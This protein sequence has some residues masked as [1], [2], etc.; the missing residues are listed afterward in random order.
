MGGHQLH[1]RQRGQGPDVVLL[2]GLASS[3]ATWDLLSP[4]LERD[5][6]VLAFDLR[7]HGESGSPPG[8]WTLDDLSADLR[9]LLDAS[10]IEAA[11]LVGHSG[12]AVIA[13]HFA[14][15]HPQ[16]VRGLVLCS[17]AAE[18]NAR[19]ARW[20]EDMARKAESSG[21]ASIL[22]DLGWPPD[23]CAP[24][25]AGF[26]HAARCMATLHPSPLTPRLSE[27]RRPVTILVGSRDFIGPGGSVR[28]QRAIT[29]S[30]LEILEGL[31]HHL[32]L[33]D[34]EGFAARVRAA[35]AA[36]TDG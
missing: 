27:L 12:G 1:Y 14:L 20:Y 31:G 6:R 4:E 8:P 9:A 34:P 19:A 24:D 13:L 21:G 11:S 15:A 17:A 3:I 25:G 36:A 30:K 10:G 18:A 35:L 29:G 7:A 16:R 33:E 32:H 28:M 23:S 22:A 2:H 5:H 26:A